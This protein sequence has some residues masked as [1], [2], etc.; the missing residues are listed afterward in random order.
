[1]SGSW[2]SLNET[3]SYTFTSA[4]G[5]SQ[6]SNADQANFFGSKNSSYY[7][8]A[9]PALGLEWRYPFIEAT[10]LGTQVIEPIAQIIARPGEAHAGQLPNEDA[11]SLVFDDTNLFAWNKFS[12]YDRTEGGVRANAGAQ[13]TMT[14][15]SGMSVNALFGESFQL[16]GKNSYGVSDVAN[17]ATES[18]LETTRSDYV[19]RVALNAGP[20]LS[21]IA[22]SRFNET[23]FTPEAVDLIANGKFGSASGS[24]Q[25]SRYAAQELIGYPYRRE[26]VLMAARY[27]FLDHYFA[28]GSATVDLNPYKYDTATGLYDLKRGSA[29]LAVLGAGLGYQDDCTTV[30]LNYSRS[31]T[32]SL[33]VRSVDQTFLLQLTLRTLADGKLQTGL[34][35]TQTVQDGIYR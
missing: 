16:A 5:F 28:K 19:A 25:Y 22:R 11:Q 4:T 24:I 13:Y 15:R 17:V 27:D 26:G 30:S 6:I 31:A 1:M 10:A 9:L 23:T 33:G 2:L 14:F 29:A 12:G 7:G 3:N 34:G 21:F 20:N 32:D 35:N 8:S 18:G